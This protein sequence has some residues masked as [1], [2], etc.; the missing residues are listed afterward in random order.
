MA[1]PPRLSA[2]L[3]TY[4]NT[5]IGPDRP[6]TF[7]GLALCAGFSS[8][9]QMRQAILNDG[10]PQPSRDYLVIAC[11]HIAD[12][13]EQQ[14]LLDRLNPTFIK[15]LLSAYL[16]ISEKNISERSSTEDRT[17]TVRWVDDTNPS[18]RPTSQLVSQERARIAQTTTS[19]QA[20]ADELADL[21]LED[22]L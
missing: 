19:K 11:A 13:Y 5:Q 16:N 8:F 6:P 18:T 17:I 20:L 15:Y 4:F 21:E 22:I 7:E 2:A 3:Q 10:H 1:S 14:G 9:A 12:A